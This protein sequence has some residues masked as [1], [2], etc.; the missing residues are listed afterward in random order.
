MKIKYRFKITRYV[1]YLIIALT[2]YY[3]VSTHSFTKQK[4][5]QEVVSE[6]I[7]TLEKSTSNLKTLIKNDKDALND[8]FYNE[9]TY[10]K[11]IGLI[12]TYPDDR[13]LK[14][15]D[16]LK[17]IL[18]QEGN[19]V[20]IR[21]KRAEFEMVNSRYAQSDDTENKT[22]MV[23]DVKVTENPN[24]VN[25]FE[26]IHDLKTYLVDSFGQDAFDNYLDDIIADTIEENNEIIKKLE[27][28][29]EV[30]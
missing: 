13:E 28:T 18:N 9:K 17:I 3:F 24:D 19:P 23:T 22:T 1:I 7:K 14:V 26:L 10:E 21:Y 29:S 15:N 6:N 11:I 20:K 16:N 8:F 4:T 5:R 30:E 25:S 2:A 27:K 12:D